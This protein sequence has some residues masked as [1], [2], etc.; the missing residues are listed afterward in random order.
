MQY[1]IGNKANGIIRSYSAGPVG[2]LTAK[3][4]NQPL[5]YFKDVNVNLNFVSDDKTATAKH[6]SNQLIYNADFIDSIT[7]E[8]IPLTTKILNLLF[9]QNEVNLCSTCDNYMSDEEHKIYLNTTEDELYQVFVFNEQGEL[10]IAY[11]KYWD[12]YIEV[13][14]ANA[15][16]LIFYSYKGNQ[17]FALNKPTNYYVTLDLECIGNKEDDTVPMFIHI[18]KCCISSNK[19]ISLRHSSNSV[20]LTFTVL[21]TNEDYITIQ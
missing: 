1:K 12:D 15:P 8:G 17:S 10:E 19:N 21:R 11:G 4:G 5:C 13:E 7:I 2:N 3:Y 18:E 6:Q 9:E 16:Y 14:N 20:D